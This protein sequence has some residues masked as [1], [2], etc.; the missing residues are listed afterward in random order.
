MTT[1]PT[2]R[3]DG[4]RVLLVEDQIIVAM[5]MEDILRG[6]GCAVVGPVGTLEAAIRL[7]REAVLDAAILDVDLDGQKVFPVAE[8]LQARGIPFVLA[9]GYGE[10]SLPENWRG[11]RRLTKPFRRE[12]IEAIM[13]SLS[14]A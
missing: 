10:S 11:L 5:E 6:F 7:A 9:T 3:Y 13:R 8:E 14:D 1:L 2:P 4:M 12:H